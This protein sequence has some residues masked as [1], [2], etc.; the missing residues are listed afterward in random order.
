MKELADLSKRPAFRLRVLCVPAEAHTTLSTLCQKTWSALTRRSRPASWRTT[1]DQ[2]AS[3]KA[4][5]ASAL[6][7]TRPQKPP[8]STSRSIRH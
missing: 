4:L 7:I 5:R 1:E 8:Q 6:S 3:P 2:D